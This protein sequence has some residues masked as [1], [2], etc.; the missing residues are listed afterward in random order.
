M[1]K[2]FSKYNTGIYSVTALMIVFV[3]TGYSCSNQKAADKTTVKPVAVVHADQTGEPIN[4]YLFGMFTELLGNMFE[5]GTWAEMIT[6]RKF[7]FPVNSDTTSR[8]A[9][10]SLGP[11]GGFMLSMHA[12]SARMLMGL[13]RAR[14]THG[15]TF[16]SSAS[17][18][19]EHL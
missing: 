3:L 8:R 11:I 19:F 15:P 4:P 17:D 10:C 13:L 6:D 7:F 16:Q 18:S 2:N 9:S 5:K 14:L 12:H 1:K